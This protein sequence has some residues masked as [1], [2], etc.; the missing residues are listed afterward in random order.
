MNSKNLSFFFLEQ[1]FILILL[2]P[3]ISIG[4]TNEATWNYP[5]NPGTE[6]WKQ[7]DFFSER[8]DAFNIPDS[9]LTEI[10]TENLVKT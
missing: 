9:I 3:L 5:V 7:L 8:L 6:E 10:T 4:Q 2:L 1:L